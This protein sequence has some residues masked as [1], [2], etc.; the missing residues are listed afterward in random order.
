ENKPDFERDVLR[1]VR[2]EVKVKKKLSVGFVLL[3]VLVLVAV[4]ALAAMTLNAYYEKAIEKEGQSG[5]IQDW[6]A[7]DKVALVDWMVEAGAKLDA[8]QVAQLHANHLTEDEQGTLALEIINSYYPARDGILTSVD[9]IAKEKGPIEY[10]SLEDKAWFSEM[11]VKYQPEE[12][13]GVNLLPTEADITQEQ[14]IEIMYAYYEKEYGLKR[15]DFDESKMSISFSENTWDDGTGP[16]RLKTW[17]MNLWLKAD[18]EHPMAI[19]ILPDGTVKQASGPYV[20][21]WRD[22]W[23]AEFLSP[24]FQTIE[25]KSA[26][27]RTWSTRIQQLQSD[28]EDIPSS[29]FIF[30]LLARRFSEPSASDIVAEDAAKLA[31][32]AIPSFMGWSKNEMKFYMSSDAAY[33]TD[34]SEGGYYWFIYSWDTE[35]NSIEEMEQLHSDGHLPYAVNAKI[36]AGTGKIIE[37]RAS[38][39]GEEIYSK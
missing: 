8:E 10:W 23:H 29:H 6:S 26:F 34:R 21:S 11:I 35:N 2:G 30:T 31:S 9:I 12:V 33:C 39:D 7:S 17:R 27:Q 15:E 13:S 24:E 14:A 18:I 22:E 25:G 1:Q 37:I 20:A 36:E 5:L 4:T 32:D 19:S 28:G 3:I 16:E 38:E